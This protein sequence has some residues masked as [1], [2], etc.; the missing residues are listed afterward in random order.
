MG[1]GDGCGSGA[2]L[3]LQRPLINI[4]PWESPLQ[5]Q[6]TKSAENLLDQSDTCIMFCR[7]DALIPAK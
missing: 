4:E 3:T 1:A 5:F 7:K 6:P 2:G